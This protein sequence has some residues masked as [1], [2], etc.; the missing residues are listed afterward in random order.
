M[1]PEQIKA[2]LVKVCSDLA[3]I[4]KSQVLQETAE[5]PQASPELSL[6]AVTAL[7]MAIKLRLKFSQALDTHLETELDNL[8]KEVSKSA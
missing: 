6:I 7:D 2:M 3:Y 8:F 4:E 1:N 5:L